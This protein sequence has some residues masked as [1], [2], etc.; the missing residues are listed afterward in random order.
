VTQ[1]GEQLSSGKSKVEHLKETSN[2]L[3]GTVGPELAR[4]S[5]RFTEDD[6]VILKHHGI[7]QQ[8]DRD[9]RARARQ[10]GRDKTY[11]YMVRCKIPGGILTRDQ[12]LALDDIATRH[13]NNTLRL[14]TRQDIQFHA[15]FKRH[16][17]RTIQEINEALVTTLG[18][19]GDVERNLMACPAPL[20]DRARTRIQEYAR[21]LSDQLL[22]RTKAYHEIWVKGEKIVSSEQ[23]DEEPLY[24]RAYLPRKFKSGLAFPGDNCID[25]YSQD[26]GMV[27]VM[28]GET[29]EGFVVLA[30]GGLGMTHG[31][32]ETFPRLA[33]PIAFVAPDE[34]VRT[35]ETIITIQR[36]HGDRQNR[37][38]ARMKYLLHEWGVE[39]F[40][41][42]MEHRLGRALQPPRPLRWEKVEDH[43][44]WHRQADGRWFLGVWV[45]NGRIKDGREVRWKAGFRQLL[46]RFPFG[47]RLTPQQNILFT[48]IG[49][50]QPP[51]VEGILRDHQVAFA[52]QLPNALRYS[53]ACPALPTCG[54]ALAEA[55]RALPPLVRQLEAILSELGLAEEKL[56][57]RM[58]GCPN[59]CSRPYI[60]DIGF[61]GRT[62]NKY[63]IYLGGDFT[64]TR[65]N[66][67]YADMVPLD[68]L[69][70]ALKPLL[71][72]YRDHRTPGEGFGDFCHRV[73]RDTLKAIGTVSGA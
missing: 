14:T 32:V 27:P 51:V 35:V 17:K 43:L 39:R 56:S 29:L 49:D 48:D 24:G 13:G 30:G 21:R 16:L 40:R 71:V 55:E 19:C 45:E 70:D 9:D 31:K 73:G 65:L 12:Y 15:V 23:P 66:Q 67:L 5:D 50:H 8:D 2:A 38:H 26:I 44:G 58:A 62:L 60:G 69:A 34:L 10:E 7:Y 6:S 42:E 3:R 53:M 59:G 36:D 37:R 52:D 20:P 28:A 46:E 61:V 47:V 1:D 4:D 63:Q 18:A 64:G 57:I 11:F 72:F 54:L 22:P 33:D 68:R 41:A 25:V